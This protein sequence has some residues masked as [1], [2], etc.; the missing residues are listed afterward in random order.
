MSFT[1][2]NYANCNEIRKRSNLRFYTFP[3]K[4]KTRCDKWI[5]ASGN[6]RL[7]EIEEEQLQAICLCE[8]HFDESAFI[9]ETHHRLT[10]SAVPKYFSQPVADEESTTAEQSAEVAKDF[11]AIGMYDDDID[12]DVFIQLTI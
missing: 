8:K 10:K 1:R 2:C 9:N 7:L 11:A 4:D 5:E 3:V 12:I 6:R